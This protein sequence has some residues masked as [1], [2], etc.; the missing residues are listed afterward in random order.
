MMKATA[1]SAD[2]YLISTITLISIKTLILVR[3]L[4]PDHL[5]KSQAHVTLQTGI[6]PSFHKLVTSFFPGQI[7]N[8]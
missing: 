7:Q 3:A 5:R 4:K 1:F 6:K 2:A 8:H